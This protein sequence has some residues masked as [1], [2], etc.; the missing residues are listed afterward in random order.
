M[1][2]EAICKIFKAYDVRG[3]Y[4]EQLT[5]D[6]A[7][8]TGY[9]VAKWFV[10]QIP[11]ERK[12]EAGFRR[13]VVG[14]D[15]RPSGES[16]KNALIEGICAAGVDVAYIGMCDTPLTTFA[17]RH[18]DCCGAIMVTASH[19]PPRYNGFKFSGI[20]AAAVGA[21]S[22]LFEIRDAV[23]TDPPVPTDAVGGL[24]NV[25]M[26]ATYKEHV[27]R[28]ATDVRP[29]KIVI[30][31]SNGMAGK[32]LPAIFGELPL[33][34]HELNFTHD[35]NFVHGLNPMEE[36]NTV[37]LRT[38]VRNT[39]AD[40]GACFDGDADRCVLI[41]EKGERIA[42]DLITA[43]LAVEAIRS[44]PGA[45]IVYDL[46]SS[47][48]VAEVILAAGGKPVRER[49]GHAYMKASLKEHNAILGGELSGHYYFRD[50][51]FADSGMILFAM[52]LSMLSAT[53]RPISELVAPMKKYHTTGEINFE[54]AD[55]V[56]MMAKVAN[57][58]ADGQVD[59]L[60]G[61]TVQFEH[62]WLNL[63]PSNTEPLLRLNLE[64][65][66]PAVREAKFDEVKAILEGES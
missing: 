21:D 6:V 29:M 64:A 24:E 16:L 9:C 62:W 3:V 22:G 7:R 26:I 27:L 46:C 34:I 59:H 28:F 32:M 13:I 44:E 54:V 43:L 15:M 17:V 14:N 56:A 50:N 55:K 10:A 41:D 35:G 37:E 66:S 30:D 8:T 36:E 61:V 33:D 4:G 60:D 19:N 47:R 1:D 39:G 5:E 23:L 20:Q 11:D 31:A 48:V 51:G 53:D 63:R 42:S 40:F 25:N 18:M 45:A 2:K 52:M 12:D 65:D 49:V 57:H 38:L 58:F